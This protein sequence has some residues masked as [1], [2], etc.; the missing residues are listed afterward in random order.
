M[1]LINQMLRDLEQRRSADAGPSP[2][3]GLSSSGSV[4]QAINFSINYRTLSVVVVLLFVAG[5]AVAYSLGGQQQR[6]EHKNVVTLAAEN[7]VVDSVDNFLPQIAAVK[8]LASI[9]AQNKKESPVNKVAAFVPRNKVVDKPVSPKQ[10]FEQVEVKDS[11]PV[12]IK[13]AVNTVEELAVSP[14]QEINKTIRPF[15]EEQQSQLAFQRAIR[16]LGRGNQQGAQLAL[17]ESLQISPNHIRARETLAALLL[18]EG[19][20]SEAASSLRNGLQLMPDA[21]PLAKLY[22]RILVGQGDV[23][24]AIVALERAR[25]AVSAD[26]EY[27]ALLAALYREVKKYAQAALTYQQ[28][29]IQRPGVASYWMGLA[30][31]QDAMGEQAQALEAFQRAQ[32]AGGLGA[33]VLRY[34]QSR[35]VALMPYSSQ[36]TVPAD[37]ASNDADEFGE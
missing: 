24:D 11:T 26:P 33:E 8:P 19:R 15:T 6:V 34:I 14:D 16:M 28:V 32:R 9:P 27:H 4:V 25:P 36:E 22:A 3:G 1:S 20:V 12:I 10:T 7:A 17:E 5:L 35:I 2:L 18:N 21:T 13:A 31:S 37:G 30:L 29:L 23:A